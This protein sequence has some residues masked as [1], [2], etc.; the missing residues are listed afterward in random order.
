METVA[1]QT[2]AAIISALRGH[3]ARPMQPVVAAYVFGSV[4]R[5][6]SKPTLPERH[7]WLAPPL[8]VSLRNMAGFRNILAHGYQNL[9]LDILADAIRSRLSDLEEFADAIRA[10]MLK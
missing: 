3:F 2:D 7:G 6:E 4:G 9:N 8:A 10:K 5:G 1:S